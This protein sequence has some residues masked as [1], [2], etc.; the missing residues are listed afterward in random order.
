M[1]QDSRM[2]SLKKYRQWQ[3]RQAEDELEKSRRLLESAR[4]TLLDAE[5]DREKSLMALE[6]KPDSLSWREICYL[7]LEVLDKRMEIVRGE[8]SVL[9]QSF[10]ER[11]SI[12][13]SAANE[14]KKIEI[15]IGNEQKNRDR[16]ELY[17][18]ERR[19]DDTL[20]GRKGSSRESPA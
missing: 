4:Q 2:E 1:T 19:L 12:W 10:E 17:H 8:L 11:R 3:K 14:M 13:S 20:S 5:G 9:Q 7:H 15:L 18:A 6:E 16:T